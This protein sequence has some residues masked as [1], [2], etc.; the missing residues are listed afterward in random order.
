MHGIHTEIHVGPHV[1]YNNLL[2]PNFSHN[3]WVLGQIL[4]KCPIIRFHEKLFSGSWVDLI[5]YIPLCLWIIQI[6]YCLSDTTT[7]PYFGMAILLYFSYTKM[8]SSYVRRTIS[9]LFW[10]VLE[11]LHVDRWTYIVHRLM[12]FCNYIA[13]VQM[14][15]CVHVT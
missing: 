10:M 8:N 5:E 1:Q 12:C 7:A 9:S 6:I 11:L 15:K 2:L 4:V 3:F 13:N 14:Y